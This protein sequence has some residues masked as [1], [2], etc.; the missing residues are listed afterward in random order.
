MVTKYENTMLGKYKEE[1]HCEIIMRVC[2]GGQRG[3]VMGKRENADSTGEK[4]KLNEC[5]QGGE[6]ESIGITIEGG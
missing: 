6:D 2:V 3:R 4:D 5:R 1:N